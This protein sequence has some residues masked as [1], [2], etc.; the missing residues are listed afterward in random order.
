MGTDIHDYLEVIAPASQ[1]GEYVANCVWTDIFEGRNYQLFGLLGGARYDNEIFPLRGL[2]E[3]ASLLVQ[4][5]IPEDS[6]IHGTSWL[7]YAELL[8][9]H[10]TYLQHHTN[11]TESGL[12]KVLEV[13]KAFNE[14]GVKC[15]YVFGFDN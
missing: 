9:V 1:D 11:Y 8:K 10:E 5:G 14:E 2:P 4:R 6:D 12:E 15:R 3:K 13:M 7:N